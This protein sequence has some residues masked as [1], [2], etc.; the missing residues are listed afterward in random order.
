M[1]FFCDNCGEKVDLH[2][3]QCG[4]CG[5]AFHGIRCPACGYSGH[6]DKFKNGCPK[7]GY[8]KRI[9]SLTEVPE[10]VEVEETPEEPGKQFTN[11]PPGLFY[12]IAIPVLSVLLIILII[13][14]FK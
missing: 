10:S 8:Q 3:E 12:Q 4:N 1:G 2:D 6:T 9:D 7:C 11:N 5:S 13:I 14:L